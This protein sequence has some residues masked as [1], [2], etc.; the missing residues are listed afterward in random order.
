MVTVAYLLGRGSGKMIDDVPLT[1]KD[2]DKLADLYFEI[3]RYEAFR[4]CRHLRD[5]VVKKPE[6]KKYLT[7]VMRHLKNDDPTMAR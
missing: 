4:L 5:K 3:P 6:A 1:R 7:R 2:K